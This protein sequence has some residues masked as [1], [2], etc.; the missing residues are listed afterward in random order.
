MSVI[1][2]FEAF[3]NVYHDY[4]FRQKINLGPYYP[5]TYTSFPHGEMFQHTIEYPD[6]T[7]L[8]YFNQ[9]LEGDELEKMKSDFL[10][11]CPIQ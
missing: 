7:F 6:A 3:K 4:E 5:E 11:Y 1:H 2:V 8:I 9:V 10:S